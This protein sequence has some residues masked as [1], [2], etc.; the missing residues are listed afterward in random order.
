[1]PRFIALLAIGL[2]IFGIKYFLG[3]ENAVVASLILI[4]W[5]IPIDTN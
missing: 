1:M 3:F 5:A 4:Y 2:F